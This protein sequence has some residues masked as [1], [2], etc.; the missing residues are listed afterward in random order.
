MHLKSTIIPAI[1]MSKY[2]TQKYFYFY[3]ARTKFNKITP[4]MICFTMREEF[5]FNCSALFLTY[6]H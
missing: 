4:L 2:I 6:V 5:N 3:S 1:H